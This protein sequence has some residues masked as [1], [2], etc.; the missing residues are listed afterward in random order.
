MPKVGLT[1]EE[2][3]V[4]EWL[5]DVGEAVRLGDAVV[6]IETD[7]ALF[8]VE[9]PASGVVAE[10]AVSEG[11]VVPIGTPIGYVEERD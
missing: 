5:F 1:T 7:K 6:L 2:G 3:E 4:R 8:E 9:S 10:H 11:G